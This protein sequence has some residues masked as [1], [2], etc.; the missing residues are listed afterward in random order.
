MVH[1]TIQLRNALSNV[2]NH[3]CFENQCR[4][5]VHTEAA[6]MTVISWT[7]GGVSHKSVYHLCSCCKGSWEGQ[8]VILSIYEDVDISISPKIKMQK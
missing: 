1:K 6:E 4:H 3:H 8:T 2:K 7:E 5:T